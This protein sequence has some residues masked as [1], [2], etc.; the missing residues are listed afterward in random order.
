MVNILKVLYFLSSA[1]RRVS[2]PKQQMK[3]YQDKKLRAILRFAND[4]VPFYH[5]LYQ[6][7]GLDVSSIRGVEDL[8][9][10]PIVTKE[11]LKSLSSEEI[12]SSSFD[13]NQLKQVKT[14]GSTG[15]PLTIYLTPTEDAWRKSIYMRA[16]I[17]CGQKPRDRWV[18]LTAPHHFSDTTKLQRK[19]GIYAQTCV[20]LFENSDKKIAKIEAA[21]PQILDG[22][23]GSLVILAKEVKRRNLKSIKPKLVFGNAE[24]IDRK[25][26]NF[27]EDIFNA[28]YCDQFG[29]AEIDRSAWQCLN[30]EGYHMDID[31][32]I[33]EFIGKDDLPISSGEH[34]E[35]AYTSL[36]N[37]AMPL[38]RYKIGDV[39]ITS[40]N[41]CSCGNNLP[42]MDLVEGRRDSFLMLPNNRIVSPFAINLEASTFKYFSEI[43]QYH[44][45]QKTIDQLEVYLKVSDSSIDRQLIAEEFEAAL[46]KMLKIQGTDVR[47]RTNFVENLEFTSGGKLSSVS[48]EIKIPTIVG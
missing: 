28:P 18:V 17:K 25:S 3:E 46:R 40:S 8:P 26:R 23:S 16:N 36:F 6:E 15:N 45:R 31:S 35:I 41:Q 27:I 22:Y 11:R 37:F 21:K 34:G 4:T 19:I 32:V 30:R 13:I 48:S 47:I 14:S 39:G 12:V 7:A 9:K 42:L 5:K 20:S 38:I 1:N 44:I 43:D 10:L 29:C 2:W 33:T 24:V